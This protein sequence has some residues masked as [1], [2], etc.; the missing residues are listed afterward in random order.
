M[1][2][3]SIVDKDNRKQMTKDDHDRNQSLWVKSLRYNPAD[4]CGP[5]DE[6]ECE[7]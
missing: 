7:D 2:H 5:Q 6:D 4:D 1:G 3:E